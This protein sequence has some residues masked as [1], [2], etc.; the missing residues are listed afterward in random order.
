MTS[1]AAI[2]TLTHTK[3][4][5][6]ASQRRRIS[7]R[8][9]TYR[10]EEQPN[11]ERT[12][13]FKQFHGAIFGEPIEPRSEPRAPRRWHRESTNVSLQGAVTYP[14][15]NPKPNFEG[16]GSRPAARIPKRMRL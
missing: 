5:W 13:L 3:R 12:L 11:H 15:W 7:R 4:Y 1:G 6:A 8:E 9:I 16:R 14:I 2:G 10:A